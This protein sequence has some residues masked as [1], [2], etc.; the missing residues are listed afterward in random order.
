LASREVIHLARVVDGATYFVRGEARLKGLV[1]RVHVVR[2]IP[3]EDDPAD[4]LTR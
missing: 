1:E 2:V 4:R 3:T